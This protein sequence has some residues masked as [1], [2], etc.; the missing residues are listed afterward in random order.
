MY[1]LKRFN[2][3]GLN[4]FMLDNQSK[5]LIERF[6]SKKMIRFVPVHFFLHNMHLNGIKAG[7]PTYNGREISQIDARTVL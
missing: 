6:K 2:H 5:S 3:N 4:Q 1:I 7:L